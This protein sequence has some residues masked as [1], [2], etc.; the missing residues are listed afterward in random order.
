MDP[1]LSQAMIVRA[2][3]TAKI[4]DVIENEI[5]ACCTSSREPANYKLSIK[6][7]RR[8][9]KQVQEKLRFLPFPKSK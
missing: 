7:L 8:H 5:A 9:L 2:Q 4:S 1:K 6:G 3:K